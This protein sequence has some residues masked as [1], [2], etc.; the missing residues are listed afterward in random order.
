MSHSTPP[1]SKM[2]PRIVIYGHSRRHQCE[3]RARGGLARTVAV[4]DG[5]PAVPTE[6]MRRDLDA[7]G[8]LPSL[9]LVAVDKPDDAFDD[10]RI[11]AGGDDLFDAAVVLD[12]G[13]EDRVEH[14]VRRQRVAVE[15]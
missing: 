6:G 3:A 5:Q 11:G 13:L 9:V 7:R 15:L 10:R 8:R 2:S 14:L 1:K 4:G 12:V